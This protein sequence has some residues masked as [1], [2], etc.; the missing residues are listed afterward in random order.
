MQTHAV[1]LC[2]HMAR[3]HV[4]VEVRVRAG[5]VGVD[6]TEKGAARA[7]FVRV[8]VEQHTR[9][10]GVAVAVYAVHVVV[11]EALAGE[12]FTACLAVHDE[13]VAA[14]DRRGRAAGGGHSTKGVLE[15]ELG[16]LQACDK[17]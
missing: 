4:E 1:V 8:A 17:A 6:V 16:A 15:R 5:I 2:L 14:F 3:V 13:D 12:E 9:V 11:D 7:T 10:D